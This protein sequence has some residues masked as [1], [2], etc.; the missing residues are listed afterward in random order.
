MRRVRFLDSRY[1]RN[2]NIERNS[3][4]WPLPDEHLIFMRPF[5]SPLKSTFERLSIPAPPVAGPLVL[6]FIAAI[7]EMLSAVLLTQ[8]ISLLVPQEHPASA[9]FYG[10]SNLIP[11]PASSR[12]QAL[13]IFG[14]LTALCVVLKIV[15]YLWSG[16]SMTRSAH[17]LAHRLRSMLFQRSTG[18][19]P[20]VLESVGQRDL[21]ELLLIFPTRLALEL[22]PL[23]A[24]CYQLFLLGT[25][26]GLLLILSARLAILTVAIFLVY[27]WI[28]SRFL[29][30]IRDTGDVAH[31]AAADLGAFVQRLNNCYSLSRTYDSEQQDA[32]HFEE[33]S[34]KQSTDCIRYDLS[35]MKLNP[36][37][38]FASMIACVGLAIVATN[39]EQ[40][41]PI[42]HFV[43]FVLVVRRA[44]S[45]I[46][47]VKELQL[48]LNALKTTSSRFLEVVEAIDRYKIPS[49]DLEFAGLREAIECK[50]L[51][52]SFRSERPILRNISLRIPSGETFAI[53]G[54]SG[55]GKTTLV[56]LIAR[57]INCPSGT[58]SFDGIDVAQ[59]SLPSLY[60]QVA[61][62]SQ[63]SGEVFRGTVRENILY[64]LTGSVTDDELEA[65]CERIGFDEF[66]A[67]C[68]HGFE[69]M[70]DDRATT[71]S[72]GERQRLAL[73]RALL[74]RP[75]I[76]ILDE[77]TNGLDPES[78][79]H[80][81]TSLLLSL[82]TTTKI[83]V[84]H[85][86]YRLSLAHRIGVIENGEMIEVGSLT[87]LLKSRGSMFARF[88]NTGS[89]ERAFPVPASERP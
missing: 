9:T 85:D 65:A 66:I 45:C 30:R 76:L 70:L 18:C 73:V 79:E 33:A 83:V 38:E 11:L 16:T 39:F 29:A 64:G 60:R 44:A 53:V 57:H 28:V 40:E 7:F 36:V 89:G 68:P 47:Q 72:G 51:T 35:C 77:F 62:V 23:Q 81:E 67:R 17:E 21:N 27:Q 86:R 10:F 61:Y 43:V 58:I 54:A 52:F 25:Y 71:I 78:A 42:S 49:G 13:V 6:S 74:R 1:V 4:I 82:P 46:S 22:R 5:L 84:T 88:W 37:F 19:A 12:T 2:A 8:V 34:L 24:V 48:R 31:R 26:S 50:D 20:G 59:Y 15:F 80:V 75:S 3:G 41:L 55:S 63:D 87:D 32:R 14:S 56:R 69:T